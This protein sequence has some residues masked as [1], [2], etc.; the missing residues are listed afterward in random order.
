MALALKEFFA[1]IHLGIFRISDLE[2]GRSFPLGRVGSKAV[3]G[4]DTL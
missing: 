2:P 4:Y 3:L 1:S